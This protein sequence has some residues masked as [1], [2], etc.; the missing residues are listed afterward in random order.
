MCFLAG[1][2]SELVFDSHAQQVPLA[3]GTFSFVFKDGRDL[4]TVDPQHVRIVDVLEDLPHSS[5]GSWQGAEDVE[6]PLSVAIAVK[7][8]GTAGVES[9]GSWGIMEA[10]KN[11]GV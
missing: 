8:S 4:S 10:Q 1:R 11:Y 7:L 3:K 9:R 2:N 5:F 6:S